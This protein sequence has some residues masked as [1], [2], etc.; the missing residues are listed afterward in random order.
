MARRKKKNVNP[1]YLVAPEE[2]KTEW[3]K[4]LVHLEENIKLYVA[5]VLFIILCLA[6]GGLIK[7]NST[8]KD[9]ETT[10]RMAE[11]ALVEDAG[12]R[13]EAYQEFSGKAGRWSAEALYLQGET[14]LE[15]GDLAAAKEAFNAVLKDHGKSDFAASALD[16][17]AF[18]LSEE[19]QLEEALATYEKLHEQWPSAFVSRRSFLAKG[20]ILEKLDRPADAVA[21]YQRQRDLFPES[22]SA[23]EAE[24][25]MEKVLERHP[26]LVPEDPVDTGEAAP[27]EGALTEVIS[28]A[29]DDEAV[30]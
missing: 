15:L 19:G 18:S 29:A 10:T 20:E 23:G 16:G 26:E 6:I 13:L 9:K 30:E 22:S 12:K 28:S 25:A 4:F 8:V 5:G 2:P 21:A 27:E 17:I 11:I 14:A 7:M 1:D 24:Q 3:Q